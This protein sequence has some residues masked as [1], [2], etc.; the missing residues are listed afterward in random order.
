VFVFAVVLIFAG[1]PLRALEVKE[2]RWGFDGRVLPGHFNIL[3][4]RIANPA[5]TPFEGDLELS[6]LRSSDEQV[7][8][9]L[10]E[11]IYLAPNTERA[12]QFV[13][14][15]TQEGTW[16]LR[17]GRRGN[18]SKEFDGAKLA[19]PA[20]V[21]LIDPENLGATAARLRTFPDDLFPTSVAATD[22]LDALVLDHVPRWE[23]T[24]R[25]ALLGWLRLGGTI[26]LALGRNG[27]H[28]EF[29]SELDVLNGSAERSRVG[30]G[31]VLRHSLSIAEIDE[32]FL[33][34]HGSPERAL[35][36]GKQIAIYNFDHALL[37]Q[38]AAVTQPEITWWLI[39]ALTAS[40]V[41]VVASGHYLWG[42]R[43]DYR[44]S[45]L[46]FLG[47][48]TAYAV[49]FA[50]AGRRGAQERQAAHSVAF[51]RSLGAAQHDVTEW[52]SAFVTRGKVYKLTHDASANF[53]SAAPQFETVNGQIHNGREG[54]FYA[55]MPL[56]S[57]RPFVHRA[58]MRGDDTTLTVVAWEAGATG[59]LKQLALAPAAR[60]PK[61]VQEVW[62]RHN[63]QFYTMK[64][65]HGRWELT[66]KREETT[67]FFDPQHFKQ[68]NIYNGPRWRETAARD[69]WMQKIAPVLVSRALGGTE[70]LQH[71]VPPRALT[72]DQAQV[73]IF[74]R[75][76]EGFQL[77]GSNFQHYGWVLYQ[78][79]VFKDGDGTGH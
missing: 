28:P 43:M 46:C 5:S 79:D 35:R 12:V 30:A 73:F 64:L 77:R 78:E 21:V 14:L 66:G 41:V 6:E 61:Q 58:V 51:A 67:A 37:Q 17:W 31:W 34:G 26:H 44:L 15:V 68:L 27:R 55:D 42:R 53:Y 33:A 2:T 16:R 60:F 48:V 3:S 36:S 45:I 19:G 52:I 38:L 24:R 11:P 22:G 18:D 40:Y 69:L 13:P 65:D 63:E 8:A 50:I 74:A 9:P 72:P 4:V 47:V 29:S 70:Q 54:A 62:A 76:P 57:S 32:T 20:R 75:A 39:Y 10:I 1:L 49:A 25:Q 7:G 23:A 71:L 56:Y 59:E